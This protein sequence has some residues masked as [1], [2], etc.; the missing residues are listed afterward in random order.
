MPPI[1]AKFLPREDGLYHCDQPGCE[2]PG[3]EHPQHLGLHRFHKHGITS[4]STRRARS[5]TTQTRRNGSLPPLSAN[6]VCETVL[7]EIAPGGSIPVA[8]LAAYR[9][10]VDATQT[11]MK[12][13]ER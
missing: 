3:Y 4:S 7:T 6:A 11:F 2:Q 12:L 5:A 1:K 9:E 10:W 8:A 13:L